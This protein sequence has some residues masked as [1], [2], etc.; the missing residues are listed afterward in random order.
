MDL[1]QFFGRFHVLV[2]HLPIGILLMAAVLELNCLF[3]KKQRS[4]TLNTI[5]LWGLLSAAAAAVLGYM[6][7]L[8][9]GYS[10]EAVWIHKM[11]AFAVIACAL[12]CWILFSN[13]SQKNLPA[14]L[15]TAL[16]TCQLFL[17]FSTGH[18]GANMTHG[19]TYLF[20]YAPNPI[21][22][23]AGLEPH[24]K[25]RAA[26]SK[27]ED[28][29]VYLDVVQPILQK[30][31]VACHNSDKSKGKL[32]LS[33]YDLVL[34]GGQSGNTIVSGDA[35]ASELFVRISLDSHDKKFMPAGGKP[36]LSETQ[37][38][39][40][41]WWIKQGAPAS[42]L[43][44]EFNLA[45]KDKQV[46]ARTLGLQK[47]KDAW[48]LDDISPLP[49]AIATELT[50][51]GFIVKQISHDVQYIDLDYSV[52]RR[53]LSEQAMQA[54]LKAKDYVVWLN[55]ANSQVSDVQVAQL[56]QLTNLIKLRLEKNP[57]SSNALTGLSQLPHLSYLNL[58]Q[59]QVDDGALAILSQFKSLKQLY[60]AES[61]VSAT[62][63]QNWLETQ[64]KQHIN[65]IAAL[66]S[67]SPANLPFNLPFKERES[68]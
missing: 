64:A 1:I 35:Q 53:A 41:A 16:C 60:L 10:D 56:S 39:S 20:D 8:S 2:L 57:I 12:I 7:S 43:L 17:L 25:P 61:N 63:L 14:T 50:Q 18:Y 59:T 30:R 45:D 15:V 48:P 34:K 42:G 26:I 24:A 38:A 68:L 9:G 58:Y 47:G 40:I 36:P 55:L 52:A 23:L 5:W 28:A 33:H 62:A 49:Q 6:L 4:N 32:D 37:I 66:P 27:L 54:L 19:S 3:F 44:S 22:S 13:F 65:V 67:N 21:R 11:F 29:D 46:L 51:A 31:C